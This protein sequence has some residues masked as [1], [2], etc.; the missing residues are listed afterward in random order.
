MWIN[1]CDGYEPVVENADGSGPEL[2]YLCGEPVG[3]EGDGAELFSVPGE[4]SEVWWCGRCTRENEG[5][6]SWE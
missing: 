2:C 6:I 4:A 5:D 3:R 1:G